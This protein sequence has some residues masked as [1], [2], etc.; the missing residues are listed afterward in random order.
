[1]RNALGKGAIKGRANKVRQISSAA[2]GVPL[3]AVELARHHNEPLAL[4]LRVAINARLDSLHLD[5]NLLHEVAKN[6]VGANFDEVAATLGES[7]ETLRQQMERAVASGVL[8]CSTDRW[9]SFTHPL[10]RRAMSNS[11]ME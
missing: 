10:L 8:S 3:F 7:V 1:M 9:L 11:V 2:A 5:H 6:S 4:P